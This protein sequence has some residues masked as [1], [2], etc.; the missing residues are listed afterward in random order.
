M[1]VR[2]A[3]IMLPARMPHRA[4]DQQK[5]AAHKKTNEHS[6]ATAAKRAG[7]HIAGRSHIAD[8][9]SREQADKDG[10]CLKDIVP[11][12]QIHANCSIADDVVSLLARELF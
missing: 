8:R 10:S 12:A 4:E 1:S 7:Q 11:P 3:L 2:L 9:C 5:N 6:T